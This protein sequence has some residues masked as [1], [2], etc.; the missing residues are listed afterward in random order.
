MDA[1][2]GGR[3]GPE[4]PPGPLQEQDRLQE[5]QPL[6]MTKPAAG[7]P[8]PPAVAERDIRASDADRDRIAGILREALAE[9]RLDPEE[10]AERID[11]VYRAKTMGELEPVV[12]DLPAAGAGRPQQDSAG[13]AYG[14]GAPAPDQ[15]LVAVFSAAVRKGRWQAP[16]RINAVA[17][18]GSVEIDLT[19]AV[20]P[21]QQIQINVT[22]V[23]GSV[24]IQV[25]Q[26]ITLRSSGSGI[27]GSFEVESHDAEDADAPQVLVNGYAVLGSVEA[28]PKRGAW[29]RDLR[30]RLVEGHREMRRQL[31]DEHRERH[32]QLRQEQR[33]WHEQHRS[34]RRERRD[35]FRKGTDH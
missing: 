18:F 6:N 13:Y 9:G 27:L 25:P 1:D 20:F 22:A 33:E 28:R 26:N 4:T 29:I 17:F 23:F 5:R 24:E 21:Q 3:P 8:A 30:D 14:P 31:R 11:T 12:R 15:N 35:R 34:E 16:A 19:E 2:N 10:H 7:A 32:H